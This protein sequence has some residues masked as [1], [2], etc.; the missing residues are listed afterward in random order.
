MCLYT[1]IFTWQGQGVILRNV[2][3]LEC[4][5]LLLDFCKN[6]RISEVL[7][8]NENMHWR[9]DLAKNFNHTLLAY[10][11]T[12]LCSQSY[13]RCGGMWCCHLHVRMETK[14][15]FLALANMYYLTNHTNLVTVLDTGYFVWSLS[16]WL[17]FN[18]TL[19]LSARPK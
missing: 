17:F 9:N 8:R 15:F 10:K 12:I 7:H 19:F 1:H 6:K 16:Q 13:Q 2:V 14:I 5:K 3:L 18:L 11:R 4:Y